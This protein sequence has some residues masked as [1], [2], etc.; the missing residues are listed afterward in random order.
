MSRNPKILYPGMK[1]K[2]KNRRVIGCRLSDGGFT[3]RFK[4]LVDGQVHIERLRLTEEAAKAV[5][6]I[7]FTLLMKDESNA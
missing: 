5:C 4:R 6:Q 3:F 1:I 2:L 7:I